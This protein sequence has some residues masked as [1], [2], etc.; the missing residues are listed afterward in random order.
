MEAEEMGGAGLVCSRQLL[1]K[2]LNG[3]SVERIKLISGE[4]FIYKPLTF[5]GRLNREAWIYEHVLCLFPP[6]YP[7]LV[8]MSDSGV[9]AERS[10]MLFEDLGELD[11]TFS[12][13]TAAELIVKTAEWHSLPAAQWIDAP[14]EAAKPGINKMAAE[15]EEAGLRFAAANGSGKIGGEMQAAA[16]GIL[17]L[18]EELGVSGT[19]AVHVL[20]LWSE[21]GIGTERVMCHGDLHLGNYALA[22]DKLKVLD[23]EH[24]HLNHPY[25]D[26][27]HIIDLSHPTFPQTVTASVR[28]RLLDIYTKQR[29]L[30]CYVYDPVAFRQGY[31]LFSSVFSLWMLRLVA[32]DLAS[33]NS[34]WPTGQLERQRHEI[35]ARFEETALHLIEC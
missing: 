5:S 18:A 13:E 3:R 14:L 29:A 8:A 6:V 22:D 25:W 16:D 7:R 28:D 10:W 35:T 9:P 27:Y 1:Y 34:P 23:W 31:Y 19:L 12:E 20:K 33:G 2:G 17:S 30:N 26:L 4:S 32:N 21:S 15:L 24:A 11:H